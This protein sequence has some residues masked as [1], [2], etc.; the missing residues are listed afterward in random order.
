MFQHALFLTGLTYPASPTRI[1][2]QSLVNDQRL[3]SARQHSRRTSGMTCFLTP[4]FAFLNPCAS[5]VLVMVQAK[6]TS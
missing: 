5:F 2:F 6:L 1:R 4:S 3:F